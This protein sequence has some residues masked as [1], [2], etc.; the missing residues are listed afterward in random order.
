MLRRPD[1]L[2]AAMPGYPQDAIEADPYGVPWANPYGD[3]SLYDPTFDPFLDGG[4][5]APNKTGALPL[6]DAAPPP[7]KVGQQPPP[8]RTTPAFNDAP[9][10]FVNTRDHGQRRVGETFRDPR[11][12]ALVRV[13]P[14]GSVNMVPA[15]APSTPRPG[16]I[17][18]IPGETNIGSS[19]SRDGS[20]VWRDQL[21]R[22]V[23]VMPGQV[24]PANYQAPSGYAPRQ[25]PTS[26]S[27]DAYLHSAGNTYAGRFLPG[28]APPAPGPAV[29]TASIAA[30]SGAVPTRPVSALSPG[31]HFLRRLTGTLPENLRR[32][33]TV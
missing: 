23:G 8:V 31:A 22:P 16:G 14:D 26:V 27:A 3:P 33:F 5:R 17:T 6:P 25:A 1:E 24:M 30:R 19:K 12:G 15:N 11:T 29:P 32:Q 9:P 4:T 28:A 18:G 20:N 21:G 2:L 13:G 10:G 7:T